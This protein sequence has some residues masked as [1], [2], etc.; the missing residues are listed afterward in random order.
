[1]IVKVVFVNRHS[2]VIWVPTVLLFSSTSSFLYSY[3]ADFKKWFLK[4]NK[5]VN[6]VL[7]FHVLVYR[8][9]SFTK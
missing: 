5:E 8:W 9:C 1:M 2:T 4:K 6:R 7:K 3:E